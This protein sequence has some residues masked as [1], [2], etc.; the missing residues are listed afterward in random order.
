MVGV[1]IIFMGNL[2][3]FV[4]HTGTKEFMIGIIMSVISLVLLLVPSIGRKLTKAEGS[5]ST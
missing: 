1:G 4:T 2:M 5:E 3:L